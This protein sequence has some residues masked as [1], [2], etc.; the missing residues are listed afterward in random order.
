MNNRTLVFEK[1]ANARDRGGLRTAQGSVI[2]PG[3]LI[4]SAHLADATA[5]DCAALRTQYRLACVIDLRTA[6][7]RAA[8]SGPAGGGISA[9]AGV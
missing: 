8:R 7:E 3:C 4:R 5:A 9:H 2:A 6:G 1:I